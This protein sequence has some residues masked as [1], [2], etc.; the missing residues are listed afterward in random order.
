MKHYERRKSSRDD[1]KIFKPKLLVN[2]NNNI[3]EIK[4][5]RIVESGI[6]LKIMYRSRVNNKR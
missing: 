5:I 1:S 6:M 2:K 3:K 4:G